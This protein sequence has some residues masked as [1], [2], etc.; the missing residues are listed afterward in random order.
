MQDYRTLSEYVLEYDDALKATGLS[1][2]TRLNKVTRASVMI[3]RHETLGVKHLDNRIVAEYLKEIGD[4]LYNGEISKGYAQIMRC[5]IEQF[6]RFIETGDVKLVNPQKGSRSVL[7]P[8]FERIATEYLDDS[9]L[10]PNTLNDARWVVHKYFSWL[11]EQ[12]YKDLRG[13]SSVQLQKFL[14]DCSAKMAPGTIHDIKLHLSK[15]YAYLYK[16][17]FSESSYK[18]L[19]SFTVNRGRKVRSILQG[20][21]VATLLSSINRET[22]GGKRAY[23]MMMLGVV[24]G[25]RACDVTNLKLTDIDWVKGEIK[26]LQQKTGETVVLPLTK[27]VGEALQDYILNGRPEIDAKQIFIRINAPFEPLKSATTIG[28]IYY[29]CC[30]AAGLPASRSFHTLRRSLGTSMVTTGTPV[31]TVAQVL[32]HVQID[33]TKRYI[34]LDSK[35]LKLCALSF[36]GI[37]LIRGAT[38]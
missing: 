21:E 2:S 19:L 15:L 24:L 1:C 34:A 13:V 16:I 6:L 17:G 10:H 23:A 8:D 28:D 32:G 14:L 25:L 27:D 30:V 31:T 20:S 4:R 33:S 26:I 7:L 18:A 38:K 5:E 35:N 11:A 22:V 12:G 29:D 3:K 9:G 37:E 36:D